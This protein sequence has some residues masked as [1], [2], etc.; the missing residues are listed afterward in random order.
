MAAGVATIRLWPL[1]DTSGV[2]RGLEVYW[3]EPNLLIKP[4]WQAD[5]LSD[6]PPQTVRL[7]AVDVQD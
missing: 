6:P 7:I 2:A 5:A 1:L 4:E 3:P